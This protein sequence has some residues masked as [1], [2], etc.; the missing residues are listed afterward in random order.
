MVSALET[1]Q[2]GRERNRAVHDAHP[3]TSCVVRFAPE[4]GFDTQ[5]GQ[6]GSRRI[7]SDLPLVLKLLCPEK[8]RGVL[9]GISTENRLR[10]RVVARRKAR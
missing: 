10:T 5:T 7:T 8:K 6:W 2:A 1:S 4:S 9:P 3:E